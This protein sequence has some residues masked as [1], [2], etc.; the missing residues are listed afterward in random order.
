LPLHRAPRAA[1]KNQRF[2]PQ[3]LLTPH[4]VRSPRINEESGNQRSAGAGV[5]ERR[6]KQRSIENWRGGGVKWRIGE[7]GKKR[8]ATG[9]K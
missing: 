2:A 8:V 5:S 4:R 3:T 7:N 9:G 1:L 6:I